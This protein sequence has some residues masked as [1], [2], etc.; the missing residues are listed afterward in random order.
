MQEPRVVKFNQA[1]KLDENG[2]PVIVDGKPVFIETD[3]EAEIAGKKYKEITMPPPKGKHLRA[4]SH[5]ANAADRDL[6]LISNLC[7]LNASPEDFD[8][9]DAKVVIRLQQALQSF[10]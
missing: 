9:A 3:Y 1:I 8:D 7:G 2:Q 5:I 6:T 4:V 10:L